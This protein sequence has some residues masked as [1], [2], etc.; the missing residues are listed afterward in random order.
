M[1]ENRSKTIIITAVVALHAF[2]IICIIQGCGTLSPLRRAEP[3]K[4]PEISKV[5]MPEP[6]PVKPEPAKEEIKI[7]TIPA[8]E[9]KEPS[10]VTTTRYVVRSGDTLAKIAKEYNLQVAEIV[11]LNKIKDPNKIRA[12]QVILLPGNIKI[13]PASAKPSSGSRTGA[14]KP[15]SAEGALAVS[16]GEEYVVK[17]GDSLSEIA[18]AHGTTVKAL[19]EANALT[20]DKIIVGQKLKVPGRVAEKKHEESKPA[21]PLVSPAGTKT[22]SM[23]PV[24]ETPAEMV[25]SKPGMSKAGTTPA[26]AST[27]TGVGYLTLHTVAPGETLES[28]ARAWLVDKNAIREANNLTNDVVSPGQ[29]LKIPLTK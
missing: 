1:K 26:G 9:E 21:E 5:P 12:G 16:G 10:P 28:I 25:P 11:A 29:V 22:E 2:L 15:S 18:K 13:K 4:K 24:T 8:V 14:T 7:P 6:E 17:P 20:T 23:A 27:S 19:K 3:E